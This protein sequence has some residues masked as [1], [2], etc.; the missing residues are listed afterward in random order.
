MDAGEKFLVDKEAALNILAIKKFLVGH[1]RDVLDVGTVFELRMAFPYYLPYND[2]GD[3]PRFVGWYTDQYIQSSE[4]P[5][6]LHD[7][8]IWDAPLGVYSLGHITA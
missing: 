5:L 7:S 8:W 3:G 6:G 2:A 1:A 4:E